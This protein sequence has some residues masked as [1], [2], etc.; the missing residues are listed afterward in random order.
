MAMKKLESLLA[1]LLM[2]VA[3]SGGSGKVH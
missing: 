3:A 1:S 2:A